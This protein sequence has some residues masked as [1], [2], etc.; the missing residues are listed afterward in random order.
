MPTVKL[1]LGGWPRDNLD[2]AWANADGIPVSI[3]EGETVL[4]MARQLASQSDFFR[5]IAFAKGEAEF[6]ANVMVI[7]NGFFVNPYNRPE[8]L[9]NEG[10]EVLL[11][12][13]VAGG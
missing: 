6:G 5:K 11:L 10:D 2:A 12:P 13:L 9:L 1:K 7:V 3:A 8:A 4:G